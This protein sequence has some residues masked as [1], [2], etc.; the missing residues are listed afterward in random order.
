MPAP[1]FSLCLFLIP[2]RVVWFLQTIL[3][4]V[5]VVLVLIINCN[6]MNFSVI[7]KY[8]IGFLRVSCIRKNLFE[9]QLA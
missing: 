2:E 9:F 8:Y 5:A 4:F 3:F 1:D 6:F 7:L